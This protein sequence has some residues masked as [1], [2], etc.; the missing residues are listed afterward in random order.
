MRVFK[1]IY[2]SP[3]YGG[4][5]LTLFWE[6]EEP[7]KGRGQYR[8]YKSP[9]GYRDWVEL[10]PED[11]IQVGDECIIDN[12]FNVTNFKFNYHY[13]IHYKL[14]DI[15]ETSQNVG[16]Y[17]IL[18]KREFGFLYSNLQNQYNKWKYCSEGI[19]I[20]VLKPA[21][22]SENSVTVSSTTGIS[23]G[24]S[25]NECSDG[26]K[27]SGGYSKPIYS[28]GMVSVKNKMIRVNTEETGVMETDKVLMA[29]FAYPRI[30]PT[31]IIVNVRTDDRYSLERPAETMYMFGKVPYISKI[32]LSKIARNDM[33]YNIKV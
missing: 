3:Y 30:D 2:L 14:G 27:F 8:F 12:T 13:R 5:S 15:E 24:T 7:F 4:K 25:L 31:D 21:V 28:W 20:A 6:V 23:I 9:D 32:Y 26:T 16:I 33:A 18:N 1:D 22:T 29:T 17:N 19:R 11:F 10:A